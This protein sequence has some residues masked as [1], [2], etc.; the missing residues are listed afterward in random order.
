MAGIAAVDP[1]T[2]AGEFMGERS[3]HIGEG[4]FGATR[5]GITPRG[6]LLQTGRLEPGDG[7]GH[8]AELEMVGDR[9]GIA[10]LRLGTADL[11]L[12]FSESGFDFPASAIYFNKAAAANAAGRG[13]RTP[14]CQRG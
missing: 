3:A 1:E 13:V 4:L 14:P 12:D 5:G 7:S 10:G 2:P 8:H 9:I 11:L 6:G